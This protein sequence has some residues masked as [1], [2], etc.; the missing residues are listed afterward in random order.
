MSAHT[1]DRSNGAFQTSA[2]LYPPVSA[3]YGNQSRDF[4][5]QVPKTT[6]Y[7]APDNNFTIPNQTVQIVQ[8]NEAFLRQRYYSLSH[9]MPSAAP[10]GE[11][12][13]GYFGITAAY[14]SRCSVPKYRNCDQG[15]S[16]TFAR[17]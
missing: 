8:N 1:V 12:T 9:K 2:G 14:P 6:V 5:V 17:Q 3:T 11:N 16:K 10:D 13:S 4:S 7:N 15:P